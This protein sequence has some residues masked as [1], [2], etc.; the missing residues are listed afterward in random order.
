M[1]LQEQKNIAVNQVGGLSIDRD[2]QHSLFYEKGQM[3]RSY[4]NNCSL[5][6]QLRTHSDRPLGEPVVAARTSNKRCS[7]LVVASVRKN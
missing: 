2:G 4:C 1:Y 3:L 6:A 7:Q 5:V